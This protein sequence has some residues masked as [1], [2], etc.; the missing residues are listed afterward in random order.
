MLRPR[1][2]LEEVGEHPYRVERMVLQ[3]LHAGVL[4]RQKAIVLRD[5]S[6]YR[7]GPHDRGYTLAK[8]IDH[9]RAQLKIPVLTGLPFGHTRD[10]VSLPIGGT[11]TLVG[12][13]T[14]WTLETTPADGPWRRL[15]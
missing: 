4:A 14:G 13:A 10:K 9:L 5:F 12:E 6:D 7:L 2:R 15:Q 3:L 1:E 11:G 8:V